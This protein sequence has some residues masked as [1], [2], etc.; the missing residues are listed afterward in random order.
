MAAPC[1]ELGSW[2]FEHLEIVRVYTKLP[3]EEPDR[4]TPFTLTK[5][6]TVEDVA[7]QIH[8][9]V[10]RNLKYARVWGSESFDGQQVVG[11]DV[12]RVGRARIGDV[13]LVDERRPLRHRAAH[14]VRGG[15]VLVETGVVSSSRHSGVS[16][17][18]RSWATGQRVLNGQPGG[19]LAGLGMSPWRITRSLRASTFGSGTGTAE[20]SACV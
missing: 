17:L 4:G 14:A 18:Q 13:E 8:K 15:G 20:R 5:G 7:V 19:G 2:L 12:G 10:A 16:A 3:G 6:Q 9:D 11:D 1:S